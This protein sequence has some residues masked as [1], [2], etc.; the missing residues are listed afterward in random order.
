MTLRSAFTG[1]LSLLSS[2]DFRASEADSHYFFLLNKLLS[3]STAFSGVM[4]WLDGVEEGAEPDAVLGAPKL[5]TPW[6]GRTFG[7]SMVPPSANGTVIF[8][9]RLPTSPPTMLP[10]ALDPMADAGFTTTVPW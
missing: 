5:G 7:L 10:T 6:P 3:V 2:R 4:D 9:T 1:S 8:P